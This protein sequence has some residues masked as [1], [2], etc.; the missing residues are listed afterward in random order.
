MEWNRRLDD[1]DRKHWHNRVEVL[2]EPEVRYVG[3]TN[4][5][6]DAEDRAVVRIRAKLRA[7]V[8]DANGKHDHAEGRQRRAR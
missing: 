4:R 5:E 7:Y 3:I 6:D 1:F 2:G 8:E